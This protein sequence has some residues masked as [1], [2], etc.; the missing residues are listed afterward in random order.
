MLNPPFSY[1]MRLTLI[2]DSTMHLRPR[3]NR[4]PLAVAF[5]LSVTGQ[6][7]AAQDARS[8]A[9]TLDQ[10]SVYGRVTNETT[11]QIP[12][13]VDVIDRA[14]IEATG[15]ETVGDALRFIPGA[16]RD[17]STLDAFGDTYLIRGFAANQTVNGMTANPLRQARDAVA[18]ERIEVLKGPASVLY[19]QLQPGALVNIVTKQPE[20]VWGFEGAVK[21]ARFDDWRGT[22]DL[23]GPL[24]ADGAVR[25]RLAGAV[26]DSTSF[27]DFWSREHQFIAPS[28]AIDLGERTT[29]TLETFYTRNRIEGFF[30]GLPAEGTVLA[31]AN[32]PLPRALSLVDPTFA[33]SVRSNTDVSARLEHRFSDSVRYRAAISWTREEV[34]EENIFGVLGWDE[35]QRTLTRAVLDG[36]AR[37]EAWSAHNDLA[38]QTSTGAITHALVAGSD[39]TRFNRRTTSSTGLASSLDLYAPVY[40]FDRRPEVTPIPSRSRTGD[41][42]FRTLGLFAQ[43]RIGLTERLR[44]VVGARWSTYRQDTA[45]LSGAGIGSRFQQK[46]DAWT[47]QLGL[48]YT[49]REDLA[50]F[51]NRTTSFLPVSGLTARGTPLQPETGVQYEV[52]AKSS[53]WNGRLLATGALF[54]LERQNVA[55][56]DRDNP[57]SLAAIGQQRSEGMDV[58]ARLGMH[59]WDV[60]TGYAYTRAKTTEDTNAALV[61]VPIRNVPRHSF[62]LQTGYRFNDGGLSG[63]RLGA[64]STYIGTRTGDVDG[65]FDLPAYWRT[66]LSMDYAMSRQLTLGLRIDNVADKRGYTHAFSTFE[67][68]PDMPRTASFTLSYRD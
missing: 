59:G 24:A 30:N 10:I 17:G 3:R 45:S 58:S 5:A 61:G 13:T 7:A 4:L 8:D 36:H 16:S 56:S 65:S 67:V 28:I 26:D 6:S 12:Q 50:L 14:M 44:A 29:L 47:S 9:V 63:L 66:D 53:F 51:A 55:V 37:G 60:Q 35:P 27:V 31:N 40:Q 68:W 54:R 43:D 42:A 41:E 33:P 57:S 21:Y 15:S 19:G 49:P 39:Y 25:F 1:H 64:S 32:G 46:Q 48:L 38:W 18:I 2:P 23:T 22:L 20:S 34:D 52:G 62:A 11:L